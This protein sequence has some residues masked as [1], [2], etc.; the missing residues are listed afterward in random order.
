[1]VGGEPRE[2]PVAGV[3]LFRI[4]VKRAPFPHFGSFQWSSFMM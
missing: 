4:A 1:M 3:G 2:K